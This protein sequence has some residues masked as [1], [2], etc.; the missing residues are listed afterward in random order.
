MAYAVIHESYQQNFHEEFEDMKNETVECTY[1]MKALLFHKATAQF[2]KATAQKPEEAMKALMEEVHKVIKIDIWDPIHPKDMSD[3]EKK[4]IIP[5]M[6][7]Y[8]E[9]YKPDMS[10]DKFKVRVLTRGNKQ[11]YAGE[12]E[13]PMTRIELLVI[14]LLIA[15]HKDLA[16]FKVDVGS[17]FMRT[18]MV[19][20]IKHQWAKLDKIMVQILME[21]QPEKYECYI[22][23]DGT[24]IA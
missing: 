20:D 7:N 3:D 13:G 10:F 11:V 4:M 1:A 22:F 8:L 24:V 5:Q 12:S 15:T 23:L 14:M 9:K 2:R 18:S 19:D 21:M 17:A 6:I 16:I